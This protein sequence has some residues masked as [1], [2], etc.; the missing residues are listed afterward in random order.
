MHFRFYR[1]A[2]GTP[3]ILQPACMVRRFGLRALV[4][5]SLYFTYPPF[6]VR[7]QTRLES[8]PHQLI[9]RLCVVAWTQKIKGKA[10]WLYIFKLKQP[11]PQHGRQEIKRKPDLLEMLDDINANP[12]DGCKLLQVRANSY[13][14]LPMIFGQALIDCQTKMQRDSFCLLLQFSSGPSRYQPCPVGIQCVV[15]TRILDWWHPAFSHTEQLHSGL[16]SS[17]LPKDCNFSYE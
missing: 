9:G 6:V 12:D 13:Y 1:P 15:S 5:R 4:I 2:D 10:Q 8:D 7:Y 3:E 16:I 17:L 11:Q 14:P